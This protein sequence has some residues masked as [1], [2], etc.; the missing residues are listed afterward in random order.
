ML[1]TPLGRSG[2][3]V[4]DSRELERGDRCGF[5]GLEHDGASRAQR[6]RDLPRRHQ[7]RIVPGN[8]LAAHADRL[9]E[10]QAE[11]LVGDRVHVAGDLGGEAAVV[12]EAGRRVGDVE[13]GLRRSA[14][15]CSRSRAARARRS[16]R[17]A[18]GRSRAAPGRAS[19]RC[20]AAHVPASN[21]VARGADRGLG[22]FARWR[23][24]PARSRAPVAGLTISC[25]GSAPVDEPAADVERQC[26]STGVTTFGRR[27][28][29][30]SSCAP[31]CSRCARAWARGTR[32][33][34]PRPARGRCRS[35]ACRRTGRPRCR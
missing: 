6:R 33:A 4:Q 17:A 34:L 12:L 16:T 2:D 23:A 20:G 35:G 28:G 11:R 26:V 1:T 30:S 19:S 13:L 32:R 25:D 8:D 22:L 14:S 15:P 18:A 31:G 7:Q 5:G 3:A 27:T 29:T 21:A 9:L 10:R 24:P